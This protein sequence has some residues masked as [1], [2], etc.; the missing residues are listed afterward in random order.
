[1][2]GNWGK[3]VIGL[4]VLSVVMAAGVWIYDDA[5]A[6]VGDPGILAASGRLEIR[7]VGVA[8]ATGGRLVRLRTREGR[9][10]RGGD[11]LAVMDRR[12]QEAAVAAARAGLAAARSGVVAAERQADALESQLELAR[13]EARRYRRL[14]ER[15]AAPRQAME[16]A[17]GAVEQLESQLRAAR[18]AGSLARD[19]ADAERA[20]LRA[21]E[22]QLEETAVVAPVAGVVSEVLTRQGEMAAP[23][24]PV[25]SIRRTGEVRL[26]V[27]LPLETAGQIQ[28]GD[29][30]RVFVDAFPD[31][32][33]TG[34]V[35]SIAS[36]AEFTP[37]D[38]HMPDER[39]TLVYEV[40]LD[41]ADPDGALKDGFPADA[42]I[43][44]DPAA[45]W[46]ESAPW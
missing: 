33:F 42:H 20:R 26:K 1:M 46:P 34:V 38:I 44:S 28:V 11:T 3:V 45:S 17:E 16:Q 14:L 12:R 5:A 35:A 41:V 29:S 19:R 6:D 8:S 31:R 13:V 2:Q 21:A 23:G 36:E 25:V 9:P 15:D 10:V 4:V 43:R 39:T 32:R 18:A 37:R 30:A 22:I 40:T 24:Y 27:Y 7:E